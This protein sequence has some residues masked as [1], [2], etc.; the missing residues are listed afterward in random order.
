MATLERESKF[1]KDV[2]PSDSGCLSKGRIHLRVKIMMMKIFIKV[3]MTTNHKAGF[4]RKHTF[5]GEKVGGVLGPLRHYAH[6]RSSKI[7]YY[8][9]NICNF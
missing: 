5:F 4:R 7:V 3:F 8:Q 9:L 6:I 1:T 2:R